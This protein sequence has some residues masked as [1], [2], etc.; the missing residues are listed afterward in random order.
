M[1]DIPDKPLETH[2]L[3]PFLPSNAKVL[4]C[5]TFPP[6][7]K[8]W[9]MTFYYPNFINDFW[10]VMGLIFYGDKDALVDIPGKTFKLDKIKELLRLK[11]VAMSDTGK[12]VVRTRD[13][14]SDK[15]LEIVRAI[16]L[17]ATL[18]QLP[19]CLGVATTGEKAASVIA[20]QTGTAVPKTGECVE[21]ENPAHSGRHRTLKHW[22]MPSTSRAYPLPLAKKAEMY[23]RM[24]HDLNLTNDDA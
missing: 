12:E 10:R 2:P 23:G 20:M 4:I 19:E 5:G 17:K 8:R 3:E 24:M 13:N 15:Y 6:Q 18:E 22:R 21:F 11:G 1:N 7:Q 14:A 9:S 16:D